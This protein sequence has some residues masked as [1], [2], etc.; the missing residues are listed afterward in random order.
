MD[1]NFFKSNINS[2]IPDIIKCDQQ[3]GIVSK[4][5][6]NFIELGPD[7]RIDLHS[8]SLLQGY[9]PGDLD[10]KRHLYAV[11]ASYFEFISQSAGK[12]LVNSLKEITNSP[13][14]NFLDVPSLKNL[15]LDNDVITNLL[16]LLILES[17]KLDQ[18]R[19]DCE[20]QVETYLNRIDQLNEDQQNNPDKSYEQIYFSLQMMLGRTR[21]TM[22]DIDLG[23]YE[24][25]QIS[26]GLQSI[27]KDLENEPSPGPEPTPEIKPLEDFETAPQNTA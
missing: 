10:E 2:F 16:E 15:T 25:E 19:I 26:K 24:L 23:I 20:K 8:Y 22:A 7:G 11:L 3:S 12:A 6:D 5:G 13:D 1:I 21:Q 9:D 18:R 14:P 17:A 27:L 4:N